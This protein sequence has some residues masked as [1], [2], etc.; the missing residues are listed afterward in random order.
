V[1]PEDQHD[2]SIIWEKWPAYA[3]QLPQKERRKSLAPSKRT[4]EGAGEEISLAENNFHFY[5]R[6]KGDSGQAAFA[7]TKWFR[8][9]SLAAQA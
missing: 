3:R 8:A 9:I 4:I 6:K 2:I 1:K 5:G 7:A